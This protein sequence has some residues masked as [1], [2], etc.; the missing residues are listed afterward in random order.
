MHL[1]FPAS[2]AVPGVSSW[3]DQGVANTGSPQAAPQLMEQAVGQGLQ[4]QDHQQSAEKEAV[5]GLRKS[6]RTRITIAHHLQ[7]EL[8]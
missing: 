1:Y 5:G 4:R 8:K 2:P 7:L 6:Q 3:Y